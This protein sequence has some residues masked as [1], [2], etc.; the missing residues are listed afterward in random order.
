VTNFSSS[1]TKFKVGMFSVLGLFAIFAMT[2]LVNNRPFWWRPCQLVKINVEDA[3]GLKTKSPI[4]SLGIEIGYLTSVEL[5]ETHVTLGICLTAPV[6]V[7][8][9]TR[10][11]IRGEGFLGDKFVELKPVKYLNRQPI[12]EKNKGAENTRTIDL[13]RES[14][15]RDAPKHAETKSKWISRLKSFLS[16]TAYAAAEAPK[17]EMAPLP[18]VIE[19][20]KA[21]RG[22]KGGRE[23]P[24]GEEGQDVQH[25]V[26]RVDELVQE[27]SGLTGNLKKT[28]NPEE[29]KRTMDQLN[30]T[31][32]NANK[33]LSPE[34]GINQTAQRTLAKLEDSIEQLRDQMTRV[35]RGEGSVGMLLNDPSYAEEIRTAIKNVNHLLNKVGEVRF[36]VNIGGAML[37]DYSGGRAWFQLGV[38]PKPDRYYLLG[39]ASDSRG[40][41]SNTT[42]TTT[43]VAGGLTQ[44]VSS[45]SQV[46]D[47]TSVLPIAMMGKIFWNRLDLS[48]GVLYGDGA[49]SVKVLLGPTGSENFA[50]IRND[51]YIR[52]NSAGVDDRISLT[53]RPLPTLY[54]TAGMESVRGLPNENHPIYSYGAGITFDDEDIK[55][56]FAFK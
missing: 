17:V 36:V 50:D 10:A 32:Q 37:P 8:G 25:L 9:S 43:T 31:L 39:L 55:L 13:Y 52:T 46:L 41:I 51:I 7:L 5:T 4:R 14:P 26:G 30:I 21:A 19:T 6:E 20:P 22:A 24:V 27:M 48:V 53:V 28:L 15:N 23:I 34:G 49:G 44:V 42:T 29:M 54:L 56:L 40:R 2:V 35:N 3:T 38:W 47:Q 45:H 18:A 33:T 11:Y 1:S 16:S 12:E